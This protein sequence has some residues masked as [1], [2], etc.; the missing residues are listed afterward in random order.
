VADIGLT[1]NSSE[2]QI[3]IG[4][5][6]DT[7]NSYDFERGSIYVLNLG[8]TLSIQDNTLKN[9]KIYPNP[10]SNRI[11]IEDYK[12]IKHIEIFDVTG[13]KI[14]DNKENFREIDFSY[15]PVGGYILRLIF[16]DDRIESVKLLKQ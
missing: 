13:R 16:N 15:I 1:T 6:F 10:T 8:S 14:S 2:V 5:Y 7:N 9:I 4:A 12:D 11:Y 3:G